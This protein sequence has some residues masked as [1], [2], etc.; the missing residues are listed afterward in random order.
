M[1]PLMR[2]SNRDTKAALVGG[3]FILTLVYLTFRDAHEEIEAARR[4][5]RE[6]DRALR[7]A[8]LQRRAAAR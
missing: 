5:A 4:A 3:L 8:Y 7:P 1:L 2:A 6:N